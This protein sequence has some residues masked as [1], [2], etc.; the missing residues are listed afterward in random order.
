M[1]AFDFGDKRI[2]VAVGEIER[3]IAHPLTT[4]RFEDNRRRLDSIACMIEEWHPTCLII[5]VPAF[6]SGEKHPMA[7][8]IRR[9]AQR[10]KA[11]FVLP[12]EL[13]DETLSSWDASRELSRA[14]IAVRKQKDVLDAMAACAILETW[15]EQKQPGATLPRR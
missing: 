2:G 14:G 1:L 7:A 12:I 9:F 15:F 13:I 3:G 4:I 8:K 11:R 10:L 6:E 5:G